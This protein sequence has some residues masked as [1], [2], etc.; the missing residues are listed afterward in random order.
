MLNVRPDREGG[1][2]LYDV[3]MLRTRCYGL[4]ILI[5][6]ESWQISISFR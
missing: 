4:L 6:S 2:S 1:C 3:N 5:A